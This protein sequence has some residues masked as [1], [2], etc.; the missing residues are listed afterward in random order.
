MDIKTSHFKK[1]FFRLPPAQ[2]LE[3]DEFISL[4]DN[5]LGIEVRFMRACSAFFFN[6]NL[7]KAITSLGRTHVAEEFFSF[8]GFGVSDI[9]K[10][11]AKIMW[12]ITFETHFIILRDNLIINTY[13]QIMTK[14]YYET[15]VL[16][17]KQ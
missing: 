5:E 15:Y 13:T 17:K 14:C 9:F 7:C 8:S 1:G 4:L 3:S 12:N 6:F 10:Q 16:L 11:P 2:L